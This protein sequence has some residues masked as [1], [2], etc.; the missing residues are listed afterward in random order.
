MVATDQQ[1]VVDILDGAGGEL[2]VVGQ[3]PVVGDPEHDVL[4]P[5]QVT[6]DTFLTVHRVVV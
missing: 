3:R 5:G 4:A 1:S 6:L 2:V